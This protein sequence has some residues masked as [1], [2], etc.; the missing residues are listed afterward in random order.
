MLIVI[1][2]VASNNNNWNK[3]HGICSSHILKVVFDNIDKLE[4]LKENKNHEI[5]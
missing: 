1:V 3:R 2:L 5:F 4:T